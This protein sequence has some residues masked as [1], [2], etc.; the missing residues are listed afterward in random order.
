MTTSFVDNLEQS[1]ARTGCPAW[2]PHSIQHEVAALAAVVGA[3]DALVFSV[4]EGVRGYLSVVSTVMQE[5]HS[6]E[7]VHHTR[8][9]PTSSVPHARPDQQRESRNPQSAHRNQASN[10][11]PSKKEGLEQE[12]YDPAE[13]SVKANS[14]SPANMP[15]TVPVSD[16]KKASPKL[17]NIISGLQ[18]FLRA[19][20]KVPNVA[21]VPAA[22]KA[23]AADR[24]S[25]GQDKP[26]AGD[27]GNNGGRDGFRV[28][29]PQQ[30]PGTD[31][32]GRHYLQH[33]QP[34]ARCTADAVFGKPAAAP[35]SKSA[36]LVRSYNSANL[37]PC[38]GNVELS[39]SALGDEGAA[40]LGVA[41]STQD[42][43][44][45]TG[46]TLSQNNIGPKGAAA[47]AAGFLVRAKQADAGRNPS[48]SSAITRIDL[49]SNPIGDDGT[50]AIAELLDGNNTPLQELGL[51]DV[52]MGDMGG[53]ALGMALEHNSRLT[54]LTL[55]NNNLG[56][57]GAGEL[58]A[59]IGGSQ[60]AI[61]DLGLAE[62]PA[63]GAG[64]SMLQ[65]V[66]AV[67]RRKR[68]Y[69]EEGGQAIGGVLETLDLRACDLGDFGA[70]AVA[71]GLAGNTRLRVL[72]LQHNRIGEEGALA[73]SAALSVKG[74]GLAALDLENN[75]LGNK[76]AAAMG[77]A[78]AL[79]TA[80]Q[81]LA[82][83]SN[84]IGS[85]GAAGLA[86]G[87]AHSGGIGGDGG[88]NSAS[89]SKLRSLKLGDNKIGI[90]GATAIANVLGSRRC[91]L[92]LLV[93]SRCYLGDGGAAAIA[94]G[95]AGSDLRSI[96]L[97]TNAIGPQ[98][99]AALA[100]ALD[101][102]R[103]ST[104]GNNGGS[105]NRLESLDLSKNEVGDEGIQFIGRMLP[106]NNILQDVSL[107]SNSITNRGA[108]MLG[109]AL[110]RNTKVTRVE[111]G[112]RNKIDDEMIDAINSATDKNE[113]RQR[114]SKY[115]NTNGPNSGS[116]S[117]R[118]PSSS[119]GQ[120][121]IVNAALGEKNVSSGGGGFRD[122]L[123]AAGLAFTEIVQVTT[124]DY[125][126]MF[127][128]AGDTPGKGPVVIRNAGKGMAAL[129]KWATPG[130][131]QAAF[132][133]TKPLTRFTT[134]AQR[135]VRGSEADQ[136]RAD[137]ELLVFG[138]R[139]T[140]DQVIYTGAADVSQIPQ[141]LADLNPLP[142]FMEAD[143]L[144]RD[145]SAF[146][147]AKM[148]SMLWASNGDVDSGLHFDRNG[149][150]FLMQVTG[151]KEIVMFP[152][153]DSSNLYPK[154]GDGNSIYGN[155][156]H[157]STKF[158]G[159]DLMPENQAKL[160]NLWKTHPHV[161]TL[162][163]GDVLY[164]PNQWWHEVW[165]V[166]QSVAFSAWVQPSPS[167]IPNDAVYSVSPSAQRY[168]MDGK[169]SQA[170][171]SSSMIF[172]RS[173]DGVLDTTRA[174]L[175]GCVGQIELR[176]QG[177]GD[178]GAVALGAALETQ[179]VSKITGL[180]LAENNIG[181]RGAAAIAKGILK[182]AAAADTPVSVLSR[183][184]LGSNPIGDDGAIAIAELVE[185]LG[186]TG[187]EDLILGKTGIQDLGAIALGMA[188][189]Q[190][191]HL[192]RVSLGHNNIGPDGA[193]ELFRALGSPG[194]SIRE[195]GMAGNSKTAQGVAVL[196][197]V[198]ANM[199]NGVAMYRSA[200]QHRTSSP[201]GVHRGTI[202]QTL[203]LRG[204]GI[205]DEEAAA[206][207]VGISG[208][209]G[210]KTLLL[211]HNAI[212]AQGAADLAGALSSV[213]STIESIDLERNPIG[214]SGAAAIG[215]ALK[216]N[217]VL[218]SVKLACCGIG[219]KG[220][221][222]F[223]GGLARNTRVQAVW[224]D[225]NTIGVAGAT[226]LAN[227]I[228]ANTALIALNVRGNQMGNKGAEL[229]AAALGVG[230][231]RM[232]AELDFSTNGVT[233][234]GAVAL[235]IALVANTRMQDLVVG[236]GDEIDAD[237]HDSIRTI[238]KVNNLAEREKLEA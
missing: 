67:P 208:N 157:E 110:R 26:P 20:S 211:Q 209:A 125:D 129:E 126:T 41:L 198:L 127:D 140:G 187:V 219:D 18:T 191:T 122:V 163:P 78:L 131:L 74:S 179:D 158:I 33:Q 48:P 6:G 230:K 145:K 119:R 101:S 2:T 232:L 168:G 25:N 164:N 99:A 56:P 154:S 12:S 184:N 27:G 201:A 135:F 40:A 155:V 147:D 124:F 205:G 161:T 30:T 165:T 107:E 173:T 221:A 16:R 223:A 170:G 172:A 235:A 149:G 28:M 196:Q 160:P 94:R 183:L 59:G 227:A 194:S 90:A 159:R 134:A 21:G 104:H 136:E 42:A 175:D 39:S 166:G 58:F 79:N 197:D 31:S 5:A 128:K 138:D 139:V 82:L 237:V 53:I 195:L 57:D 204:C 150:G 146:S 215:N 133:G 4:P 189:E 137:A 44:G 13:N 66:L 86:N 236:N 17:H 212:G 202:L 231:N 95:L 3:V 222:G 85:V 10:R 103:S 72:R 77:A 186:N 11:L 55:T 102:S 65:N 62:N 111:L 151:R 91:N 93:L 92:Q 238:L 32:N 76:G 177:L 174:T 213:H 123:V 142:S 178:D 96:K 80:L 81:S 113:Q 117:G 181:A 45:I 185:G 171:C 22:P 210:I 214:D 88:S 23:A 192:K 167:E 207:A 220:A 132:K 156:D 24:G 83:D 180:S 153:S 84:K 206:L 193:A 130:Y 38:Y 61:V 64:I 73:L 200:A 118:P 35:G 46:F 121:G 97:Q 225:G 112:G 116:G 51:Q 229:F 29:T 108:I 182:S 176:G 47:L 75:M 190:N 203:D 49:G 141:L 68:G 36:V 188:M 19:G 7:P 226:A 14:G 199:E 8:R 37:E 15:S 98:G 100:T 216:Q 43:P 233:N 63:I 143:R 234:D 106:N 217:T 115:G 148:E 34:R 152:P 162:Y 224:L 109:K 9:E 228:A 120:G 144:P 69:S 50:A 54:H 87:L 89:P 114:E 70:K 1:L 169:A 60:S 105:S 71:T 218:K 52:G